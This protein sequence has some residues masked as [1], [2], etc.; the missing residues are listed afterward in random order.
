MSMRPYGYVIRRP[1]RRDREAIR[2]AWFDGFEDG[3]P[4]RHDRLA[5]RVERQI[6]ETPPDDGAASAVDTWA[7]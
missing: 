7:Y 1:A 4:R 3:D 2:R 6:R 5:L